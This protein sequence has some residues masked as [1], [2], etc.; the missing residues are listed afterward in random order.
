MFWAKIWLRHKTKKDSLRLPQIVMISCLSLE[1]ISAEQQEEKAD[2]PY[3]D[4]AQQDDDG[5]RR[6]S[7]SGNQGGSCR[8]AP[9]YQRHPLQYF[10]KTFVHLICV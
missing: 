9:Y 6:D 3:E 4:T 8:D 7:Y 1:K 10:S 5:C 2:Y